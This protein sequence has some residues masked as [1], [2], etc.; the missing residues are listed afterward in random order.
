MGMGDGLSL[1][2]SQH[3]VI[4]KSCWHALSTFGVDEDVVVGEGDDDGAVFPISA[5]NK[6][7]GSNAVVVA[8]AAVSSADAHVSAAAAAADDFTPASSEGGSLPTLPPPQL[9]HTSPL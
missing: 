6:A 5:A 1:S 2:A 7:T 8:V 3:R 4:G 9:S